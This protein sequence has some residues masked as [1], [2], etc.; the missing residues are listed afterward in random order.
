MTEHVVCAA[1][2]VDSGDRVVVDIDGL[3]LTVL[4][5][6]GEYYAYPN[7]CPHQGGPLGE[8]SVDGTTEATFDR[9]TLEYD[10]DWVKEDAILRCPWHQWEFDVEENCFLHDTDRSLPSY[11]VSVENGDIVV[12]V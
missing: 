8:G 11:S 12:S 1:T 3:E 4:N 6:D 10:L 5:V 2:D 7:W 9:E